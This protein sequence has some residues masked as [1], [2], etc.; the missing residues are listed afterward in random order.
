MDAA[1]SQEKT[2]RSR[3]IPRPFLSGDKLAEIAAA[4]DK[5]DNLAGAVPQV[6][7][8]QVGVVVITQVVTYIIVFSMP[9][10]KPCEV[11]A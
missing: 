7:A 9:Y 2:R 10:S 11:T 8:P 6:N 3:L 5:A 4:F 1:V